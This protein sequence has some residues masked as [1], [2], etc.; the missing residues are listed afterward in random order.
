VHLHNHARGLG[1]ALDAEDVERAAYPLI[2]RMRGDAE[3]DGNLLR[4]EMLVD[5][6]QGIEL[7]LTEPR[8]AL[9]DH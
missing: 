1:A 6:Q 3:L 9:D 7:S 5:E 2:D 4:R 8:D